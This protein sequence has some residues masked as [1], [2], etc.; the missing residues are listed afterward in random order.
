MKI[1][2]IVALDKSLLREDREEFIAASFD[3]GWCNAA[4]QRR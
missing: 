2:R 3:N 4:Y 1:V